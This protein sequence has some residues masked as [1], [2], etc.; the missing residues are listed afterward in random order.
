MEE[1]KDKSMGR[2]REG[3]KWRKKRIGAWGGRGKAGY[4]ERKD[5]SKGRARLGGKWRNE[6]I[7]ARGGRKKEGRGGR[8]G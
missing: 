4:G 3:G 8:K 2:A 5:R 6:R 1:G 7:G